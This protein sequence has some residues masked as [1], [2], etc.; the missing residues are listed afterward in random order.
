MVVVAGGHVLVPLVLG[1]PEGL[2]LRL[3]GHELLLDLLHVGG[4]VHVLAGRKGAELDSLNRIVAPSDLAGIG[5]VPQRLERVGRSGD[6][7][8]RVGEGGDT[9][10]PG[11]RIV[12]AVLHEP[13]GVA[14][15]HVEVVEVRN[16]RRVDGLYQALVGGF[17]DERVVHQHDIVGARAGAQLGQHLLL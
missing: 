17:H 13:L 1:R 4:R 8:G 3:Q 14:K 5:G 11:D 12:L 6:L 10:N 16:L 9:P 15:R 7:I 2:D